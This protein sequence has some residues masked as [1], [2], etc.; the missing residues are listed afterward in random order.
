MRAFVLICLFVAL[1]GCE[2]HRENR[3]SV[4][5]IAVEGLGFESVACDDDEP[6]DQAQEGF[7]IF[8]QEGVRFSHAYAPSTMSQATMASLMTGLYP[9]DHGVRH[10][11]HDFLSS[12][13]Q[14]L[15]EG[16]LAKGYHTLFVSGGAPLWRKS[17]LSQGFEIFDDSIDLSL[18]VYYRPVDEVLRL[19]TTWL[20]QIESTPFFSVLFLSDLQFP[21]V[22]TRASDGEVRERSAEGQLAEIDESLGALVKWLKARKR[23][24]STH[25]ILVGLNSFERR[26]NE[27]EPSPLSLRSSSV[28]VTLFIKPARKERDNAIHWAV[29]R[30]VSLVDVGRTMFGWLGLEPLKTTRPELAPVN[31][32]Q[33]LTQSEPNWPADRLVVS[34]TA[35]PDWHEGSG[36][37]W[38]VRQNQFLYIYDKRPLIFN[39][40][41]DRLETMALR[42]SDPLWNSVNGQVMSLLSRAHL[43]RWQG[44][45]PHWLEQIE[46]A[47]ELW[48]EGQSSRHPRGTEAWSRWYLRKAVA[49]RDW[50]EVKRLTAISGDPIGAFAAARGLG[51][52][53]PLPRQPCVRLM[54]STKEDRSD[55]RSECEDE[56]VLALH[57]WQTAKNDEE[58][59]LAQDRFMRLYATELLDQEIGRLNF[60]GDLCW[61]VDLE[62]PEA[63]ST[64]DYLLTTHELEPFAKKVSALLSGKN[65]TF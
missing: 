23:W 33:A 52:N 35:W 30:N 53:P 55:Y 46:V 14:T 28:Q 18:G 9:F 40:L 50:R 51:E 47:H 29:D 44:M 39:T 6:E 45:H 43:P 17:G 11:G 19:A 42:P 64:I 60:M 62:K 3:P 41:T 63:P 32:N 65:L 58:R 10:N 21:E 57:S 13:F 31:L 4:L 59:S 56:R 27:S 16:A 34:E 1:S 48:G 37:R 20:D 25:V 5:V 7:R 8:C 26:E 54:L 2:L 15:A 49:E 61:D 12:R 22:A 36:V 24:D 38:A